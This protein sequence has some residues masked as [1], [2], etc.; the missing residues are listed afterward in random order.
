MSIG[1]T[2][3]ILSIGS[4]NA[5]FQMKVRQPVEEGHVVLG[6]DFLR[7]SGGKAA[8]VAYQARRLGHEAWLFGCVGDDDLAEQALRP[9]RE[10]DVD[11]RHVCRQAAASTAVS[12]IG[13]PADGK[14][15]ILLALN[16]NDCW[17]D[18]MVAQMVATL[19]QASRS[20][21]AVIDAELSPAAF[22]AGL[23][24]ASGRG[25]RT[26]LD[27]SPASRIERFHLA[28]AY[29]V[30]GNPDEIEGLTGIAT[31]DDASARQA[32]ASLC[33][34]GVKVAC[35][36]LSDGG[37]VALEG[38]TIYRVEAPEV[39]VVDRTGAGDAFASGLAVGLAD[40]LD[41]AGALRL[42][43]AASTHA[44]TAYGSQASYGC[45]EQLAAL[46]DAIKISVE[47]RTAHA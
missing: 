19:G 44:V 5:D 34:D 17:S 39:R 12:V 46:C 41:I 33:A 28:Q 23:A 20:D 31:N 4:V 7:A 36:K 27:P 47:P 15:T 6:T 37:C 22:S 16:A 42:A 38:D 13:V 8:N 32:A 30:T 21:V 40:H 11:V 25:L 29:A 9:L 24:A 35:V 26:V 14:K 43:V 45:R 10:I 2:P 18:R 3:R 1:S